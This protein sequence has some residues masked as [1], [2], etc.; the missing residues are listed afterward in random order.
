M[1]GMVAATKS[2]DT[3]APSI[4]V[5]T[6]PPT[7]A[8]NG[9]KYTVS[10]TAVD[11][12]GGV[13]AGVE[14]STDAGAHWH[15]AQ[16][17]TSWSFSYIQ[18]G[19]AGAAL[20]VRGIDAR[21]NSPATA[22]VIPLAVG[23]PYS[24]FGET[25]PATADSGDTSAV[26]LG[27]RFTPTTDGYV[28]GVRFYKSTANTGT[29]T[30][31]VWSLAGQRLATVTFSGETASGWQEARFSSPIAVTA[32]TE[33]VV[34]YSTN[35][36]HYAAKSYLYAYSGV[37]VDPLHVAGGFGANPAGVYDTNGSMPTSSFEQGNYY[38]DA[39]F[40][41][42]DSSPLRAY[43]QSPLDTAKSVPAG[44]PI[45]VTFSR[46]VQPGTVN[47]SLKTSAGAAVAG[48][49]AYDSTARRATFTPTNALAMG[50][51]YTATVSAQ[52]AQG[53]AVSSGTS[54][55]FT[56][57]KADTAAGDCPC[58]LYQDSAVPTTGLVDDRT[59]LTLGMRF[60]PTESG[61]VTGVEFYKDAGNVGAHTGKLFSS[62]GALLASVNFTNNSASGW[63]YA[64]FSTPVSVVANA[65]YMVAY[66]TDG[67]YSV[68]PNGLLDAKSFGPL[69]TDANAGAVT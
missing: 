50:S 14:Y 57:V 22:T 65:E 8:K 60:T 29:H 46:A 27:L 16:G 33:Y 6:P 37:S 20:W 24:V 12:G 64:A 55:S 49:T 43:N 30:G 1:S 53:N 2:T 56:T 40:E 54:W 47:I 63:Q 4:S 17:T 3:T 35:T 42:E 59:P 19:I 44:T 25:A 69:R 26:E 9:T 36:G 21:G 61:K 68:T 67:T 52:D 62:G 13:V 66:T 5:T 23:G 15:P 11:S 38:V 28:A 32:G 31:S 58:G 39:I 10:G 51:S 48:T 45:A 7:S 34:S 41:S 18:H